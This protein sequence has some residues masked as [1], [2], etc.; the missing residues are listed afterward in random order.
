[1]IYRLQFL[2][3]VIFLLPLSGSAQ[4]Y[5]GT[6]GYSSWLTWY[7][8]NKSELAL[9]RGS[10]TVWLYVPMTIH[11]VGTD[12]G[13]GYYPKEHAFRIICD[14]NEQYEDAKIRYYLHPDQ[15]FMYHANSYWYE[16]NW[17]GGSEMIQSTKLPARV[18]AYIV[19]DPAGNCG[20]SWQDAIVM[21]KGCSGAGNTTWAHEAGHHLSLPHPFFGWEGNDWDFSQPAPQTVNNGILVERTDTSNCYDAADRFCDT[22]PDYLSDRWPCNGDQESV[23][24]QKDP[25]G[26]SFRSDASLIMGYAQDVCSSRFT[27]EQIAAMRS[28]LQTEHSWYLQTDTP[29]PDI[30]AQAVAS[31]I[32]PIDTAEVQF[33]DVTLQWEAVPNAQY[34]AVQIAIAPGFPFYI[35]NTVVENQTTL[36]ITEG[37]PNNRL[38]YWRVRPFS[39]WDVCMDPNQVQTGIFESR[40]LTSTN[41]LER[42]LLVNLS[43]NPIATGVPAQLQIISD[44]KLRAQLTIHDVRGRLY[45]SEELQL[46]SGQHQIE[47]N[48][49]EFAAG[50][51]ILSLQNEKGAIVKRFVVV[52]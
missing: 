10:D 18:N 1:M 23:A 40:N 11:F 39:D 35:Y 14:L 37:L 7:H 52:E 48:N 3:L 12:A 20:Y 51:Y 17:D 36:N 26:V 9:E 15:P 42:S 8:D 47:I 50:F 30:P 13:Y 49:S 29:E 21:G 2:L 31:L 5:C 45:H 46:S 38:L 25:D 16:H 43:P 4:N 41:A 32:A 33:N 27:P 44:E 6:T 34:Y 22:R 24:I 19:A 28:N